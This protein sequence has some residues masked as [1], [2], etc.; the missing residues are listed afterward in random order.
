MKQ[1]LFNAIKLGLP[2]GLFVFLLCRVEAADYET[3]LNQ[4]KRFDLLVWAQLVALLA[5]VISFLRWRLL[6]NAFGIPFTLRESFRLGFLGYLLNF[7]SFGSVGGDLFKAILVARGKPEKRPEAVASV[8]LD[9]AIGLLG[10][11]ILAWLSLSWFGDSSLPAILIGIRR[12]AAALAI[13]SITALLV[14]V[15]AGAWFERLI[16]LVSRIPLLGEALARMALAVRLL[17]SNPST[18]PIMVCMSVS[19]HTLLSF[20]VFLV[21][22]GVYSDSPSFAQHFM[23]IPPSMAVGALPLAP[24]GIGVQEGAIAGLFQTLENLPESFSGMLVATVYRLITIVIAGIGMVYYLAS[25][26]RE[27]RFV[28]NNIEATGVDAAFIKSA[29][30]DET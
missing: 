21:S 23:V 19:V 18:I 20:A 15:Y 17:R 14:A 7:V 12:A 24:G 1:Y 26:G 25:H 9:R 5:I 8:L 30:S 4:P 6:V 29:R 13:A 16:Q 27:F 10:L 22:K 2:V 3:F 11:L 28:R